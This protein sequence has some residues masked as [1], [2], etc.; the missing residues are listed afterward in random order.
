MDI[1]SIYIGITNRCNLN[2]VDCYNASGKNTVTVEISPYSFEK[3]IRFFN[4]EYGV[5]SFSI[6][7]GEPF[8]HSNWHQIVD[9][10]ERYDNLS[11]FVSTNGTIWNERYANLLEHNPGFYIQY[12]VDGADERT[13][14]LTRGANNFSKTI[15]S[16]SK[17]KAVNTPTI[18]MVISRHNYNQLDEYFALALK[19]RCRPSFAFADM[20]GNAVINWDELYLNEAEKIRVIRKIKE[21]IIKYN[22]ITNPPLATLKCSL[23]SGGDGYN[24]CL[25]PNGNIQPCQAL[26]DD[27]FAVGSIYSLDVLALDKKMA[28]LINQLKKRLNIDNNCARCINRSI[29]DK[30][31]AAN[32]YMIHGDIMASDGDCRLR[33]LQTA[34]IPIMEY[35]KQRGEV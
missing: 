1:D 28:E 34:F 12:S 26:Y 5:K 7:G 24:I 8:I 4:T 10:M 18:K 9:V 11:F 14:A 15:D 33:K 21:L 16:I 17:L 35:A 30:G 3:V 19:L 20:Q 2:C 25:K 27:A 29:C 6:S 22:I 32:A 31:C 13:H 23:I